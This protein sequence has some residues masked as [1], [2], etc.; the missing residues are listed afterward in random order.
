MATLEL[1]KSRL[2][3]AAGEEFAEKGFAAARVRTICDRAGANFAAVNYHFGGKEQLYVAA[4]LEAHRCG[5]AIPP[6]AALGEG[7]PAVQLRQ[8]IHFF[9]SNVMAMNRERDSWHSVL[10]LRE[11]L[12]PTA[13]LEALVREAIRPRFERL[14]GILR[15]ACPEADE[16]RLAALA[17]SVVGQCL[18]Y[19]TAAA[20]TER[21]IGPKAYAA[22]DLD[23]LTDHISG[24]CLAALG[25]APPLNAAGEM[26]APEG[27]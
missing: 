12:Q 16:L 23:Y 27:S 5:T 9:L 24:F 20:I 17:F 21:L 25:L 4:V 2:L 8:Y 22:L 3:E 7:T 18:H 15:E 13:A 10:M 19:K 14:V 26:A 1:T 6:A 11:M